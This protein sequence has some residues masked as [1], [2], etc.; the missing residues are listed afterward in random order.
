MPV[1]LV[2]VRKEKQ[3]GK[4]SGCDLRAYGSA[5]LADAISLP[6]TRCP[7]HAPHQ[8]SP[9]AG[10]EAQ[11]P[12]PVYFFRAALR[13]VPF[14][15]WGVSKPPGRFQNWPH[16]KYHCFREV[17]GA[18][19]TTR[20]RGRLREV[21]ERQGQSKRQGSWSYRRSSSEQLRSSS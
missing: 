1:G 12:A 19:D 15:D 21:R 18:P 4:G 13:R 11:T 10:H 14:V 16:S 3:G 9:R 17:H 6:P 7:S 20:R 5:Y 2:R 8:A